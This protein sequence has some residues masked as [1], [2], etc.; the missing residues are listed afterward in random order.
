MGSKSKAGLMFLLIVIVFGVGWW[1]KDAVVK[2]FSKEKPVVLVP[3]AN[4]SGKYHF[5]I[6]DKWVVEEASTEGKFISRSLF[7]A[8]E[9]GQVMGNVAQ[10]TVTI[11]ATPGAGQ[12]FSK[13]T[14]F[15]EWWNKGNEEI[16]GTGII[17][18][19][20]ES[21]AGEKAIRLAEVDMVEEN[22]EESFWSVTTWFRKDSLN[23]YVNMMGNGNLSEKELGLFS[24]VLSGFYFGL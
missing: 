12:P 23:Y 22:L 21:V 10:I 3:Y 8:V 11:V 17:K 5:K 2:F 20:N 13:Q 14:E 18:L 19:G 7:T 6:P 16:K 24:Q 15:D 9:G 4:L 1:K